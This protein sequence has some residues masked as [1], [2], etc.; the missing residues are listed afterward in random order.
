[1][2]CV[3]AG[4]TPVPGPTPS[5]NQ[6]DLQ[7][8]HGVY[9][10]PL[11]EVIITGSDWTVCTS[12][13]LVTYEETHASISRQLEEV[14]RNVQAVE[15]AIDD[16]KAVFLNSVFAMWNNLTLMLKQDLS[17]YR[18]DIDTINRA[19]VQNDAR[20]SR[21][22]INVVSNVGKY[23]FGFSTQKDVQLVAAKIKELAGQGQNLT[24]IVDQQFSYIQSV[25]TQALHN[26][27]H[28]VRLET[29]LK[30]MMAAIQNFSGVAGK[31]DLGVKYTS[32]GLEMLTAMEL[33]QESFFQSQKGLHFIRNIM[34]K[35]GEG[36]LAWELFEDPV[37]RGLLRD[38]SSKLPRGWKLL[39]DEEDHYSYLHYIATETHRTK[40][41]LNLCMAIPIIKDSSRYQLY[42][43][44]SMPV[45][46]PEFP[47]KLFF[48]YNFQD[49]F[50][51]IQINGNSYFTARNDDS[52][53]FFSMDD[54]REA[55]C[56]GKDPRVCSLHGAIKTSSGD[57]DNCL[58]D[59]FVDNPSGTACPAQVQ[60]HDGPLFRHVGLGVWLYGAAKGTL[61]VQCSDQVSRSDHTGHYRL[62]GTGAFR[63]QP[64]CEAS[65]GQITVPSYVNGQGR[66][67]VEMPDAP[68][69]NLFSLNFTLSLW[70]NI[71]S[72]LRKPDNV[73]AF[74]THLTE[75]SDIRKN[76]LNLETFNETI[77]RYQALKEH[78]SPYHPFVWASRPEGQVS[79]FTLLLLL[80]ITS[81]AILA[82]GMWKLRRRMDT[83]NQP[84]TVNSGENRQ[85]IRV[86][87]RRRH[88]ADQAV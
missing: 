61:R 28:V 26:G 64:G 58:Y 51:A 48:S 19:L 23:L 44:I 85:L 55:Q 9:F 70:S 50:L 65:L 86:R 68:I 27:E 47:D 37:F 8:H 66:F 72:G 16:S 76:A 32:M 36:K 82:A 20:Q 59:L 88:V 33:I 73:T 67:Q 21:G 74:L 18:G 2:A 5:T 1:M 87:R 49:T 22:L 41:G 42:E 29:S 7:L 77:H 75:T 10:R 4:L 31:L 79:G 14:E 54:T 13:N 15:S 56:V 6:V 35:A 69:V 24:H 62:T 78:L 17:S 83:L 40:D 12:F 11:G 80:N 60:Y 53:K 46:H 52:V 63:L 71:T 3:A 38:L 45:V 81:A 57:L 25:A 43:A 34:A 30:G 39:Y 84:Q